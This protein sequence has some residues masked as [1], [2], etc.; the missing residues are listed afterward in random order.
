[1]AGKY[2]GFIYDL[3]P[4]EFAFLLFGKKICPACGEKL[5]LVKGFEEAD[6]SILE[7]R[8]DP[9][10]Y[11]RGKVKRYRYTYSCPACG[12]EYALAE[13]AEKKG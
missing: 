12:G 8:S 7:S 2:V 4:G 13:L 10:R 5:R 1:M 6:S 9:S 11:K 3:T